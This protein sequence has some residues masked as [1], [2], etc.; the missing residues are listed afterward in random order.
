MIISDD[1]LAS[2]KARIMPPYCGSLDM[3]EILIKNFLRREQFSLSQLKELTEEEGQKLL[4]FL[5]NIFSQNLQQ[6]AIKKLLKGEEK[7]EVI[8]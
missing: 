2:I 1:T 3:A 5:E 7:I 4:T 8:R 6:Q